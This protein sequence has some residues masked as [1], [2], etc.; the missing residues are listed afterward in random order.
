MHLEAA[1]IDNLSGK[2]LKD[3]ADILERSISQLCNLSIKL[4]S[5]PRN[6]KIAKVK[7]LFIKDFL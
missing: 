4:D 3:C 5:F 7:P 6:C 1:D 2:F